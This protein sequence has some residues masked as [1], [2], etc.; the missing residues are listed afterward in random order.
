VAGG[1]TGDLFVYD[2]RS[3]ADVASFD[4]GGGFVNDVIVT[5]RAAYFTD[6]AKRQLYVVRHGRAK[7]LPLSGDVVYDGDP[8][9][10]ELNGIDATRDGRTLISVQTRNGDLFAIDPRTGV[11][12]QIPVSGGSLVDGDGILLR[13]RTLYVVRNQDNEIAVVKLSRHLRRGRVVRTLTDPDLDVPTGI[14]SFRGA[15]Y[16]VNAK[17]GQSGP[18]V[19]YEVVRVS[20]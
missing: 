6:S 7:T 20:R 2:A 10:F 9:T 1:P 12:R 3:G 19:P 17:F 4:V 14:A 15:V 13:G 8:S 11:T 16:A 18:D 5:R